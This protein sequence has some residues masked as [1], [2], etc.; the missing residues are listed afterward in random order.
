MLDFIYREYEERKKKGK[1]YFELWNVFERLY[2]WFIK[3]VW[4]NSDY[5]KMNN[6]FNRNL[7]GVEVS[8]KNFFSW[9]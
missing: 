7:R 5:L 1:E 3:I 6:N 4:M 9:L 8:K 2:I